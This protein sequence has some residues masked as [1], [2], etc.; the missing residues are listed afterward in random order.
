MIKV[1]LTKIDNNITKIIIKGHANF[2]DFGKD[3]VCA[4]VSS[5][6]ITTVNIL[7]SLDNECIKYDDTK[8]LTINILKNNDVTNKIISV[9]VTNLQELE[10]AYP[11]NIQIKEENNE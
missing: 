7:L 10:K 8:G 5:T 3:I 1:K 9:L 6:V 2:A 11:K 4:S